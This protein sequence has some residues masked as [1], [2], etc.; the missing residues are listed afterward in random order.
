MSDPFTVLYDKIIKEFK[1][2]YDNVVSY[3]TIRQ[4]KPDVL[5]ESMSPELVIVPDSAKVVLGNAS[6]ET[7]VEQTLQVAVCTGDQRLGQVAFPTMWKL[8]KTY[9]RL[10][11]DQVHG[12]DP[13]QYNERSFVEDSWT[14]NATYEL[15]AAERGM[16]GWS[17]LWPII[18]RMSFSPGDLV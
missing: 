16:F 9:Q 17:C 6:C 3:N 11:Y 18:V 5:T 7:T 8:L 1:K 14:G 2:D 12:L 4:P 13:L 10:R 15:G